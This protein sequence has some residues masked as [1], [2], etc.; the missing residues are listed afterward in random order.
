MRITEK[1]YP[2]RNIWL[3]KSIFSSFFLF[4]SIFLIIQGIRFLLGEQI[5]DFLET[6]LAFFILFGLFSVS[7]FTFHFLR[8]AY[9]HFSFDEKFIVLH[10]GILSRQQ[11]NVPY[12]VIQ[13]VFVQQGMF[14]RIFGLAALSIEDFSQ[15]GK[16]QAGV[17]GYVGS[18]KHRY[19]MLGFMGNKIHIP[20]LKKDDAEKLKIF[21]LQRIKEN[22]IEDN[23]SGL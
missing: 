21:I 3:F 7:S 4:F 8:R 19:E 23:Q 13:T 16:S 17:D 6:I 5:S 18:G 2:I 15:G 11:R 12:G 9:F 1:E 20:G 10:Q 22:P 14:E